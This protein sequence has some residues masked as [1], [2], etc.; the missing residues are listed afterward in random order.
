MFASRPEAAAAEI[1]RVVKKGGRIAL[2]TW[3]TDSTVA[4]MFKVMR[5]FMPPPPVP[6]PPS[7]F[8]WGRRERVNE[9]L[10][11]D[12][13]LSFEDG[14]TVCYERNGEAVWD[15]FVGGYGPTRKLAEN[16][17]PAR[18]EALKKAFIAFHDGYA[19]PLG[20]AMPRQYLLTFGV[21]R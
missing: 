17:E 16:L 5:E 20:V 12:F 14:E 15:V 9:L 6:A 7:P 18:R 11:K 10:G 1:A 8:E 4:G 19:G 3:R 13:D 21:R 2:T